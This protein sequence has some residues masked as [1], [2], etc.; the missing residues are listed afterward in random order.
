MRLGTEAFVLPGSKDEFGSSR[1]P[2]YKSF[3]RPVN[4]LLNSAFLWREDDTSFAR[5]LQP[6]A[7]VSSARV[8]EASSVSVLDLERP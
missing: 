4:F 5:V 6:A 1:P 8:A 3:R 7:R 2:T